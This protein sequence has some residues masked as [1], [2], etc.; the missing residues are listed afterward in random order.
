M[1]KL[2]ELF[3][4]TK[5]IGKEFARLGFEVISLDFKPEFEPTICTDILALPDDHFCGLGID[6]VW[7][8]PPCEAFSVMV[9][10][11]N[12]NHDHT[13]KNDRAELGLKIL[14]KTL[15]IIAALQAENPALMV[16]IENPRAK[17]RRMPEM[18]PH[19]A[20]YQ[21]KR[22]WRP[23]ATVTYCQYGDTRMKPTDIWHNTDWMPRPV[24]FNG[25][26]CHEAAPRGSRTGTQGVKGAKERSRIPEQ[27][28]REIAEYAVA[29][30]GFQVVTRPEQTPLW[31]EE[32]SQSC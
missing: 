10:G 5:S 25:A 30:V 17:M 16:W 6:A 31:G 19:S 32:V 15:A 24:C 12:W 2:L 28:C 20:W 11:K 3:C 13:P 22:E 18:E 27:L 29:H 8:S 1:P 21:P 4:G 23:K 14:R 7:A 9:I 26:P